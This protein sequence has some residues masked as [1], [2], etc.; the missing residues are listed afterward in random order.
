MARRAHSLQIFD[1][2]RPPIDDFLRDV[3]GKSTC[4]Y[5]KNTAFFSGQN[6]GVNFSAE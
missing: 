1:L 2:D 3:F 6:Y 4:G 5:K